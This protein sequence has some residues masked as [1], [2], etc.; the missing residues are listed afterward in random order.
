M[1]IRPA[2]PADVPALGRLGTMMVQMH[3]DLDPLRFIAPRPGTE[4][5]YGGYLGSQIGQPDSV[6]LVADEDGKIL[7]Y[8]FGHVDDYDYPSLRGPAGVVEDILVDPAQRGRGIGPRLLDA[9]LDELTRRGVPR[10]V[11]STAERNEVAQ[12]MFAKAGFRRTMVEMTRES[13]P[14]AS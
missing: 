7:G 5:G 4:K 14:A 9:L 6:L 10:V 8:A 2:T 12:R 13:P 11:L 3:Y 1:K